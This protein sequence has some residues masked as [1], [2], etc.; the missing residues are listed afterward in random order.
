MF[1]VFRLFLK[2]MEIKKKIFPLMW[3]C[4]EGWLMCDGK[5]AKPANVDWMAHEGGCMKLCTYV[6]TSVCIT[7]SLHS[8]TLTPKTRL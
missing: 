3:C 7:R 4:L 8:P 5:S 1:C 6:K 2:A